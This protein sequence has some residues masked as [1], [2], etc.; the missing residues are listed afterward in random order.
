MTLPA[1][2]FEFDR[3]LMGSV[4]VA[5]LELD[6]PGGG[7]DS[8]ASALGDLIEVDPRQAY[9]FDTP[10][11]DLLREGVVLRARRRSLGDT[12]TVV[13]IRPV[14]PEEAPQ[15]LRGTAGFTVEAGVGS[16]SCAF[17]MTQKG[18]GRP[19]LL[20]QTVVGAAPVAELFS[21]RQRAMLA[22]CGHAGIAWGALLAHGPVDVVRVRGTARPFGVRLVAQQWR[23]PDD[24]TVL[25]LSTKVHPC[26]LDVAALQWTSL[27]RKLGF[28]TTVEHASTTERTLAYFADRV[29][30][31]VA[32][33]A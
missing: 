5:G 28:D 9:Y 18:V 22:V 13:E 17:A 33:V 27:V 11:L 7:L 26:D 24:S 4:D 8:V 31:P 6:V 30:R 32:C 10:G 23:Y 16:C 1:T 15:A 25:D 2:P 20:E 12:D 14:A 19:G 21:E 3:A 29:A